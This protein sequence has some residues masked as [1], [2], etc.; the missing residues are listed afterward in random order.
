MTLKYE[1]K[2]KKTDPSIG[3]EYIG[4]KIRVIESSHWKV[5][6]FQLGMRNSYEYDDGIVEIRLI[7]LATFVKS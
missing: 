3:T 4:T 7:G 6:E 1:V 2:N 5:T